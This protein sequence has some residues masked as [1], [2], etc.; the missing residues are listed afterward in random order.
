MA[1]KLVGETGSSGFSFIIPEV[2]CGLEILVRE[3]F[4]VIF[5][6]KKCRKV[7]ENDDRGVFKWMNEKYWKTFSEN[8][9]S[10]ILFLAPW[11]IFHK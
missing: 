7:F 4:Q 8:E 2:F 11:F 10:G 6:K 1:V 5:F 3:F 9:R